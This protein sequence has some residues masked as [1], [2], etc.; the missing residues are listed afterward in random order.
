MGWGSGYRIFNNVA[1]SLIREDVPEGAVEEVLKDLI[2]TLREGD[3]DTELDSLQDYLHHPAVVR[4]FEAHG[5][6]WDD[7]ED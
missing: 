3:W 4:A 1:D 5:I 7:E 6:R 2:R